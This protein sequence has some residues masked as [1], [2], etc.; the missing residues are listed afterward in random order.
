MYVSVLFEWVSLDWLLLSVGPARVRLDDFVWF[1]QFDFTIDLSEVTWVGHM[2]V[3]DLAESGASAVDGVFAFD[4]KTC[5][6]SLTSN[7]YGSAV[8]VIGMG[9]IKMS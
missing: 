7:W 2:P 9:K 1:G 4:A 8:G 5:T 6:L 3:I